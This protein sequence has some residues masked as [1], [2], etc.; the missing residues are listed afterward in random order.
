MKTRETLAGGTRRLV[1]WAKI[2]PRISRDIWDSLCYFIIFTYSTF[3][4][5]TLTM[6]CGILVEKHRSAVNGLSDRCSF[7]GSGGIL[8]FAMAL[9]HSSFL[10]IGCRSFF[11]W[12]KVA[13][14]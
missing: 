3:P 9:E 4:R 13:R 1:S 2:P 5:G 6:F 7:P 14:A 8:I 10:L 11:F 12:E